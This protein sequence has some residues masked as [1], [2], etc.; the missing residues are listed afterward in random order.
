MDMCMCT[1]GVGGLPGLCPGI[2][3]SLVTPLI[4]IL[5]SLAFCLNYT[6]PL[7]KLSIHLATLLLIMSRIGPL[8]A[9][10]L[11]Q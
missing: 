10:F 11:A 1:A 7:D 3:K 8:R 2:S 5:R 4:D 6:T 9:R